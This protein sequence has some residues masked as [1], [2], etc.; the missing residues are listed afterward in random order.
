M[1]FSIP[2]R[3]ALV[4]AAA[5]SLTALSVVAAPAAHASSS[6]ESIF[7]SDQLLTQ[8]GTA[9]QQRTLDTLDGLGVDTIRALVLWNRFAPS[10]RST[11]KPTGFDGAN[12][13]NYDF[14]ILQ[15]LLDGARQR[16][17]TVILTP[18]SP[19]P[20]WASGCSGSIQ[21][22]QSCRP[23][24]TEFGKF[25][26]ALGA[27]F[28]SQRRWAIWNEPNVSAFLEPQYVKS[29]GRL[30]PEAARL[31]RGLATSALAAL[32]A[33]GHG[34]G[35]DLVI[36]G[37]T[38]PAG[39]SSVTPIAIRSTATATFLR[40]FLCL[41]SS[42]RRLTG[43][44]ARNLGC[45]GTFPK[46]TFANGISTHPYGRG[47]SQSPLI[48]SRPDE[49]TLSSLSRL[50]AIASAAKRYGRVSKPLAIWLTEH[51]FQTNPPDH[52]LGVS[53]STQAAWINL[54]EYLAFKDSS[55]HGLAQYLLADDRSI[56]GFQ[57]GLE[58]ASGKRKPS[59]DAYRLPLWV[60]QF[61]SSAVK[62]FGQARAARD[63]AHERILIQF[64]A[65]G[66]AT[67][68]TVSTATTRTRKGFILVT[69]RAHPGSWRLRWTPSTGGATLTSR[70]A[71]AQ[72][73]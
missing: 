49:I 34:A 46:L 35:K 44:D 64:R 40:G 7:Q 28:P 50:R 18:T 4:A 10:P 37:E 55:V 58:F 3:L 32:R 71:T 51:G 39:A 52:R 12:P 2:R 70:V 72:R 42:N 17:M 60:A 9:V 62:V 27:K 65:R 41:T 59:F 24:P 67:W 47:G 13:A 14:S 61:G 57:S 43:T 25:V 20:A 33:T 11:H 48:K 68:K 29:G 1:P 15:S 22:R 23:S 56:D 53:L 26:H 31:Y 21:T 16:G 73:S 8:S 45:T 38:A 36:V 63:N 5:L 19:A 69:L 54:S 30:V 6:Q 66:S